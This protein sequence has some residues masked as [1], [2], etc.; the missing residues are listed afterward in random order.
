VTGHFNFAPRRR[1]AVRLLLVGVLLGVAMSACQAP[2]SQR[3]DSSE[4]KPPPGATRYALEPESSRIWLQL[5]ADGALARLGHT[6]VIVAQQLR[7]DIWLHPQPERSALQLAIPVDALL[8]DD[9]RERAAAGAAFA[10]PLDAEARAGTREHMLGESQLDAA[11][12]PS[13]TLRSLHVRPVDAA[14]T[15]GASADR[16]VVIEF[17]VT[18]RDHTAQLSVPAHWQLQGEQLRASGAVEFKQSDLGIEP[19]SAL[20]GALRVA[21]SI[22]ARF[23]IVAR[24]PAKP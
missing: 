24:R 4:F 2:R 16:A 21:D 17:Q 5:Q 12:Y 3:L 22:A 20:L 7:G 1:P 19:Y 8:V 9:P 11:H 13:L 23:E 18:L 10:E 15:T 14:A 6:H